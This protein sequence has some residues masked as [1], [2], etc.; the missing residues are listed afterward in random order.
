MDNYFS[1]G[2][3]GHALGGADLSY[4]VSGIVAALLYLGIRRRTTPRG[5]VPPTNVA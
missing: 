3:V 2:P 4:F 1:T 5:V